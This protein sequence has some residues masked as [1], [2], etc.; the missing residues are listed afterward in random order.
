MQWTEVCDTAFWALKDQ[1]IQGV[2]SFHPDFAKPF[3]L[4]ME[5]SEVGLGA[6][7]SQEVDCEE[8]SV[9]YLS[10]KLFPQ[11]TNYSMTEKE[12]LVVKWA[13]EALGRKLLFTHHRPHPSVLTKLSGRHQHL[14]YEAVPLP[15]TL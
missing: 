6:L 10:R 4:Q 5:A 9:L 15:A 8:H 3:I 1:L 7:V 12:A 11:E 2:S 14:H 13:L